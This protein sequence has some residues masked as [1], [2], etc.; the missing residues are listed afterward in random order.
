[1]FNQRVLLK[2]SLQSKMGV[3]GQECQPVIFQYWPYAVLCRQRQ[4]LTDLHRQFILLFQPFSYLWIYQMVD[5]S[6][7]VYTSISYNKHYYK[8][9]STSNLVRKLRDLR[10]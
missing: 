8:D 6:H 4:K 2:P 5:L 7:A 3:I 1:M 10:L 9:G